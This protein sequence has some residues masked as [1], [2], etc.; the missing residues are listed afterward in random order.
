MKT[1]GYY[2]FAFIYFI[3]K[4]FPIKNKRV[5]C[6]ITHDDGEASNVSLVVKSLKSKEEGFTFSYITKSHTHAVKKF[7]DWRLLLSF[8]FQKPYQMARAEYILLDNVFLPYAYLRR[9][10]RAKVIQLWH[11]TGTIK[12]FGQDANTG[13]LKELE[14]RANQNIT[15]LIVN[16]E[17]MGA[18]YATAFGVHEDNIHTIGLPKTDELLLRIQK[19]IEINH[20]PDKEYIY[21]K[22]QIPKDKKLVLYAPTFRDND[23]DNPN[24]IGCLEDMLQG[25]PEDCYIGLR[26]HPFI[27]GAFREKKLDNRICQLSFET[28]LNTLLM[29]ADVLITDYSSIIFDYCLTERPMIFYAYD[30]KEFSAQGRGFYKPYETYVPG[31]IAYTGNDVAEIIRENRF[32]PD[33]IKEFKQRNY[34]YTDGK[35]TDRLINLLNK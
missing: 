21:Q 23:S 30:L 5:L 9:K 10:K 20:N 35:A 14:Y 2:I 18:L 31:P 33:Q 19:S 7:S 22:Y 3:C 4:P 26:L 29:A 25:L 8:F 17:E 12:K 13:K 32:D 6:I 34:T 15:H 16:S 28:D 27:A 24:I 1:I 11:G